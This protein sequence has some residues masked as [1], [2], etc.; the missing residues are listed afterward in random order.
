MSREI[1]KAEAQALIKANGW[2]GL[3]LS[4]LDE[5]YYFDGPGSPAAAD[6][7]GDKPDKRPVRLTH[8]WEGYGPER[9]ILHEA[10]VR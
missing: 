7:F 8:K 6:V 5:T 4:T 2:R 9:F 3:P 1:T 10:S